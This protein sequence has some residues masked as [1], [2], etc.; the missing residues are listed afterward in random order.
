MSP[1]RKQH[2]GALVTK[3]VTGDGDGGS[4]AGRIWQEMAAKQRGS[5]ASLGRKPLGSAARSPGAFRA[6]LRVLG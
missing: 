6:P 2:D 1:G 3:A 4:T 5:T